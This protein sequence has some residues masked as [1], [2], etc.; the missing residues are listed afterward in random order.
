MSPSFAP[1]WTRTTRSSGET[2]T[3]CIGDK[4]ITSPSSTQRTIAAGRLSIIALYT[5]RASSY[6]GSRSSM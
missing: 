4:S 2:I 5:A 1:A 3:P 6:P